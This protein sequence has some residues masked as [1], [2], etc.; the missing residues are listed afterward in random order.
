ME[1]VEHLDNNRRQVVLLEAL[2]IHQ[3]FQQ[4][5]VQVE[6]VEDQHIHQVD[7][8]HL[9]EVQEVEEVQQVILKQ[10]EQEILLQ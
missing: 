3:Y 1:E 10:V 8:Q 9:Q 5:Q 7:H 6:E 2:V 4:L